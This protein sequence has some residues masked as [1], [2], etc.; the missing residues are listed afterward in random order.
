[1]G[2]ELKVLVV[3]DSEEDTTLL[4]RQLRKG[5]YD[6]VCRRVETHNEMA[7]ALNEY[8]WDII[9]SD[10]NLPGF[11]GLQA[12][13]LS[14]QQG[15]DIPFI[16]V[17]GAIGEETAVEMMRAGANDYLMKDN[18][19]RL[20]PAVTRE[21]NDV[22]IRQERNQAAADLRESEE[23]YRSIFSNDYFALCV[24][25]VD[26]FKFTD[27]NEGFCKLYGYSRDAFLSGMT[28]RQLLVDPKDEQKLVDR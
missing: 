9:F 18:L 22:K 11:G 1:M 15:L 20:E 3:E 5:G 26:T 12:L 24:L 14:R 28:L 27:V 2:I 17:S 19:T 10:Y 4:L 6:P 23:K 13:E 16:V 8:E 21:L 25:S 7:E